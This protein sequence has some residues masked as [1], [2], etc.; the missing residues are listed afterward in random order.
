MFKHLEARQHA[1]FLQVGHFAD[2]VSAD[3]G[4]LHRYAFGLVALEAGPVL[5]IQ[6]LNHVGQRQSEDQT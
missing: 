6:K 5:R 2:T 1:V 4:L 3:I